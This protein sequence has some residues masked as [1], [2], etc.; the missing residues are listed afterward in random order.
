M[1]VDGRKQEQEREQWEVGKRR[2]SKRL[3]PLTITRS[4]K[5]VSDLN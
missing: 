1:E 5:F 3:A 4:D 2:D